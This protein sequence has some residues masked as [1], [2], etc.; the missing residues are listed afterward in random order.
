MQI[1]FL[2]C[3]HNLKSSVTASRANDNFKLLFIYPIHRSNIQEI[4]SG[5]TPIRCSTMRML[6]SHQSHISSGTW[7]PTA[8][9]LPEWPVTAARVH[10][11]GRPGWSYAPKKEVR[12]EKMFVF[13]VRVGG[14]LPLKWVKVKAV[15]S[16]YW[17]R[18]K[19][20]SPPT[21]S[22]TCGTHATQQ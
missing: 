8:C 1:I 9:M 6:I 21:P 10:L 15:L 7:S 19:P 13:S 22:I 4:P 11:T 3:P 20:Q 18:S 16:G 5:D 12:S 17:L 2:I 14:S